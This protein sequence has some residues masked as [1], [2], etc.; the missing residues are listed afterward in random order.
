MVPGEVVLDGYFSCRSCGVASYTVAPQPSCPEC[1]RVLSD[2]DGCC[3]LTLAGRAVRLHG[4]ALAP[5]E[6]R[7]MVDG[8]CSGVEEPLLSTT[9]LLVSDLVT[10]MLSFSGCSSVGLALTLDEERIRVTVSDHGRP[11]APPDG[12]GTSRSADWGL[13]LM[14]GLADRWDVED[15]NPPQV[16]F[17]IARRPL[18]RA[19]SPH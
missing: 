19:R 1:K 10:T 16:W 17:E 3:G 15:G 13:H 9:K 11:S 2:G 8:W 5:G 12:A 6:A 7:A 14:E 4:G 18:P